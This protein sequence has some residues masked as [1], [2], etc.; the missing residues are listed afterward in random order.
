MPLISE[1]DLFIF[2]WDNT[3]TDTRTTIASALLEAHRSVN[4]KIPLV[5][6]LEGTE[7]EEG[8]RILAESKLDIISAP[9][10]TEAA[11]MVVAAAL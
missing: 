3:L 1:Y 9:G 5:V 2:D 7:V 10:L 11:K 6:R 8:R 4:F